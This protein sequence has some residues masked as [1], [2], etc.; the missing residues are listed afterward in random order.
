MKTKIC[1]I[2]LRRFLDEE[3]QF[4]VAPNPV[5]KLTY[6]LPS[7]RSRY[8]EVLVYIF[9]RI[10]TLPESNLETQVSKKAVYKIIVRSLQKS[11]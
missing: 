10:H 9:C 4:I 1:A 11:T 6:T 7:N 8:I 5:K 2:T 3:T